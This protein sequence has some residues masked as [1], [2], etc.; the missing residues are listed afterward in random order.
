LWPRRSQKVVG[1]ADHRDLDSPS[2]TGD[3]PHFRG[4]SCKRTTGFEPATLSL[5][6][7]SSAAWIQRFRSTMRFECRWKR[8]ETALIGT[9]LAHNWRAA[10]TAYS[11]AE[12]PDRQA[13]CLASVRPE[14]TG[15]RRSASWAFSGA[16]PRRRATSACCS[17]VTSSS[18]WPKAPVPREPSAQGTPDDPPASGRPVS[19]VAVA[20]QPQTAF[21]HLRPETLGRS[22]SPRKRS[23]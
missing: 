9:R 5:G 17:S 12:R 11:A 6:S 22:A 18:G 2:G 14:Q 23:A 7:P 20:V 15:W 8:L 4:P 19:W 16:S 3:L 13:C 1:R 10:P 21:A